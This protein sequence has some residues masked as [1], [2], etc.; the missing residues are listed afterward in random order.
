MPSS[1]GRVTTDR[2]G[3][4]AKQLVGHVAK[5]GGDAEWSPD[6]G[7]GHIT[8]GSGVARL[9]A[10]PDALVIHAETSDE[11]PETMTRLRG[12]FDK[13]LPRFSAQELSITWRENA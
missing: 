1:T 10:E 12:F 9:A 11:D 7:A 5:K 4:Y 6:S 3:R 2:A 8:L 13:H